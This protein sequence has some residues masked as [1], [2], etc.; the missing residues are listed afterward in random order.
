MKSTA[1][2][3]SDHSPGTNELENEIKTTAKIE[4]YLSK[5]EEYML[6]CSL[7]EHLN[8]LLSQK[9]LKRADVVRGSLLD[10]AYVY[11]IFSGEKT[12]SRDKLIAIAFGLRLS[13]DET[14]KMLK[15]SGNR[16]LYA[17]DK[18]DAII[19]FALHHQ[20]TLTDTNELLFSHDFPVLG[21]PNE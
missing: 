10:R 13:A 5:N 6:T 16:A 1:N 18:R 8:T 2:T 17:K 4:T 21:S 11:Q 14:Q 19:L 15:L 9:G 20:N 12:S 7:S 3:A